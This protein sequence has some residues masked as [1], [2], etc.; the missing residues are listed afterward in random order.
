MKAE[1]VAGLHAVE[2]VLRTDPLRVLRLAVRRGRADRR[3][4]SLLTLAGQHGIAVEYLDARRL[5]RLAGG[6]RHQ[7]VVAL[8]RPTAALGSDDLQRLLDGLPEAPFLLVLDGVTDPHNL[9]ACLRS[10]EAA[11][12][13]AVIAPRHGAPGLTPVVRKVASGAAE[14]VPYVQV[15]NLAQTLVSLRERGIWLVGTSDRAGTLLYDQDLTG[16]LALVMGAEGSGLRRLTAEHC[17]FLVAIPMCGQVASL[18][19]S[20]ATGVC[21][22]EAVRQRRAAA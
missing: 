8:C 3:L 18:N 12:V 15:G 17:D 16:P 22:F 6:L 14:R 7:G 21:L 10:A 9:G 11:C 19:V 20:V 5:D 2:A 13:H 1:P 4:Q